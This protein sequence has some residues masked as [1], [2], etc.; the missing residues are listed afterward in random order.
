MQNLTIMNEFSFKMGFSQLRQKDV[1]KVKERIMSSLGITTRSS[2]SARLNGAVEPKVSEAKT[3]ELIFA[4]Y[5]IKQVWGA[6][7]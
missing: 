1:P 7:K 2:W 6:E 5:G 4:D 3:I